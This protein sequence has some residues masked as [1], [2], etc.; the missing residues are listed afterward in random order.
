VTTWEYLPHTWQPITQTVTTTT[1]QQ[2]HAIITDLTGTPT[3]L[4]TPDGRRVTW[5]NAPTTLW[6]APHQTG[7]TPTKNRANCPLRF[8]GQYAD[9]E[10][11]LHYNRHRYYNPTT[12]RYTTPDPLGLTPAP[13]PHNYTPNPTRWTDPL[14]L[15]PCR[16]PNGPTAS[17]YADAQPRPP[18]SG[19]DPRTVSR[20]G[21][22][23]GSSYLGRSGHR[24]GLHSD[25]AAALNGVPASAR[26]DWHGECAEIDSMNQALHDGRALTGGAMTTARVR[27][28]NSSSHGSSIAPCGSCTPILTQFGVRFISR[29]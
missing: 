13:D 8:P 14:G 20:L 17:E 21:L 19:S 25:L 4:T 16:Q 2:F 10:T 28:P 5:T 7:N 27:G 12:A 22:E 3:E 1:D 9:Y 11:G 15:T 26:R 18:K 23:D 6:G 24:T 29:D